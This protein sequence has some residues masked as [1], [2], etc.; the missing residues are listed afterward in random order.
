MRKTLFKLLLISI[1]LIPVFSFAGTRERDLPI[2]DSTT[3][4]GTDYVRML[5]D[6]GGLPQSSN[7]SADELSLFYQLLSSPATEVTVA[8]YEV[9]PTDTI[10]HVTRNSVE[11]VTIELKT[12]QCTGSPTRTRLITVNDTG[13]ASTNNI[14]L[15]TEGVE[16]INGDDTKVL[17]VNYSSMSIYCKSSNWWIK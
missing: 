12:A 2:V 17:T 11:P 1:L 6:P 9:L 3:I 15:T 7:I 13:N 5:I 16:K 14:T 10:L 4:V 8:S